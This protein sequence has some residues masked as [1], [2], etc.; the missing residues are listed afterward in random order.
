MSAQPPPSPVIQIPAPAGVSARPSLVMTIAVM[1]LV[2]G[3]FNLLGGVGVLAGGVF[4]GIVFGF[5]PQMFN[6][7][8]FREA[9]FM[10]PMMLAIGVVTFILL[11]ALGIYLLVLAFLEL[12][13]GIRLLANP[14]RAIKP[15][16]HI[17][18]MEIIAI[19]GGN[20]IAAVVGVLALVFYNDPAVQ[21]YFAG[22]APEQ[23][24]G[25]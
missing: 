15:A 24:D 2:S 18:V 3:I 4:M 23:A 25:S 14:P 6:S 21:L 10:G 22:L 1:T 9:R 5:M 8:E 17:A 7:Y 11:L 19:V 16:R 20:I 12:R 13:Y